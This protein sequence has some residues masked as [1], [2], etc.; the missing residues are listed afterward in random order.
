MT[1]LPTSWLAACGLTFML[2]LRHG[3]DADHLAAIDAMTRL[4]RRR[5]ASF[6]RWCGALFSLGHGVVVLLIAVAA[7]LAGRRLQLPAWIEA[8]GSV[9]SILF[10]LLLGSLNLRTLLADDGS[11]PAV[12]M[13]LRSAWMAGLFDEIR[14]PGAVVTVGA[15]FAVSFD[16]LSQA[17]LFAAL[18]TKFGGVEQS[19]I[20]AVMFFAGMLAADGINGYWMSRLFASADRGSAATSRAMG[21]AVV[22]GSFA[23]AGLAA[24]RMAIQGIDL[25][26]EDRDHWL[27]AGVI[28]FVCAGWLV[29]LTLRGAGRGRGNAQGVR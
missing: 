16:T 11:R 28:G 20:L 17:L 14:S 6:S 5:G 4:N 7:A 15:A 23:V 1:E 10:L 26:W 22:V 21:W 8:V 24:L 9:S 13:G 12:P 19:A 18:G 29:T 27:S 3:V 25:W 2:G